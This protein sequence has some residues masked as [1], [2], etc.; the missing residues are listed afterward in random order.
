[1]IALTLA[2]IAAITGGS[3]SSGHDDVVV[4]AAPS[5]DSRALIKGGL[6]VAILGERVDGHAYV[7]GALESGAAA[8]LVT[9]PVPGPYVLVE[10]AVVALGALAKAVVARLH[11]L[12]GLRVVAITG[13]Q[14]K[15]TVKD[16]LAQVLAPAGEIVAA[17]G[18]FNNELGVPLTALRATESTRFLIVEMGARGIGHIAAL[19]TIAPPDVAV[20]LN[21]GQAHIGQFGSREAI[22]QAKGELVE[23]LK[24]DGVAILNAD[25]PAVAAMR[26]RT[27]ARVSTFGQSGDVS[28]SDVSIAD[29]GMASFTLTIDGT[30]KR[31]TLRLLG[32]HQVANAAAAAAV[33]AALGLGV[34][35][36]AEG[37]SSAE[38]VSSMRMERHERIDGIIIINDAYNANPDSMAAAV[39]TLASLSD[40]GHRYAVLG[41]MLE[42]DESAEE[43]HRAIGRLVS[44]LG[45]ETLIAVGEG[46][47]PIGDGATSGEVLYAAD[48]DTAVA[49][50]EMRLKRRDVVLVKASRAVGL[51]RVAAALLAR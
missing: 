49:I 27:S 10:D 9:I 21:V 4:S 17:V 36:I 20:V 45:I 46:G 33:A 43:Q 14:G 38:S 29:D 51:E 3:V 23:A 44:E 25:D 42:L 8:S 35:V 41:E 6:F 30:S 16:I 22:A 40:S 50:L 12:H 15:T 24:P 47:R 48:V 31:V 5:I 19:C 34:D 2:E 39:R 18:S 37:L 1:M 28:V 11:V 32:R 13:S 26:S 7:A